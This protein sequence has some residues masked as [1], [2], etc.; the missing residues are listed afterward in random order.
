MRGLAER[1]PCEWLDAYT[2]NI[3]SSRDFGELHTG[4]DLKFSEKFRNICIC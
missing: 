1:A 3:I 2:I 4:L